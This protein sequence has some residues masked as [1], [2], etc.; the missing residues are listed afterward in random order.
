[1]YV[2]FFL[3]FPIGLWLFQKWK[4]SG[5]LLQLTMKDAADP[6]QTFLYRLSRQPGLALFKNVLLCGSSQDHYVPIHSSHIELCSAALN[7]TTSFGKQTKGIEKEA[8]FSPVISFAPLIEF[9]FINCM[10]NELL[11]GRPIGRWSTIFSSHWSTRPRSSCHASM[12]TI[13]SLELA[14]R[15]I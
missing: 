14:R 12:F 8:I 3:T 4:K 11:Q 9:R 15:I 10:L 5:S 7:D 6:R 13:H 1:M 2:P